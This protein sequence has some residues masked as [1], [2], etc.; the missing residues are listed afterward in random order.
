M[1]QQL[2]GSR[3]SSATLSKLFFVVIFLL[4]TLHASRFTAAA[5][6][7]RSKSAIVM[8]ETTGRVLYGKNPNLKLPPASTTKLI[9]A[10]VALDRLEINKIVT[11]SDKAVAVSPIKANFKAG[12]KLSLKTLLQ[13]ALIKSA[14]DAAYA[15]A[16]AVAGSEEAFA[17][18][19][20]QKVLALGIA[21]TRFANAT[22]LPGYGQYTTVYDLA[23]IMRY[24]LRYPVIRDIINTKAENIT[25]EDGRT[26]F[27]KNI[28]KLL[29]A[30]DSM[31]GG[32]TGYT[33]E[34]RHCF[35]CAGEH[36]KETVIVAILGAPSRG[37][38]WK[39]SELLMDKGFAI[40]DSKEEPS[41]FFTR[42]DY[43]GSVQKASYVTKTQY[44]KK[45]AYKKQP[46]SVKKNTKKTVKK[47]KKRSNARIAFKGDA[48][49]KG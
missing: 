47:H 42:A 20:N 9:T 27:L 18:L 39:E 37:T 48:G 15:V 35:V 38:L 13:A 23:K 19:M 46:K 49:S 3:Q 7:V 4:F 29:W 28:N 11:I 24:A 44:V 5:E 31:V 40:K 8:D 43:K 10:M 26:I 14:N 30:D 12:E 32:K 22:G 41:V 6:E 2:P 34:A 17:E 36:N 25:T 21:D 16:E 33:R 45:A 1:K